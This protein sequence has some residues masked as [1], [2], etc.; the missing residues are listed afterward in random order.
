MILWEMLKKK[1]WNIKSITK[2]NKKKDINQRVINLSNRTQMKESTR[3]ISLSKLKI[4][5]EINHILQKVSRLTLI[6]KWSTFQYI[7]IKKNTLISL[8]F[9]INKIK[10]LILKSLIFVSFNI[11]LFIFLIIVILIYLL[12][13]FAFQIVFMIFNIVDKNYISSTSENSFKNMNS[14]SKK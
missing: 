9:N 1:K 11:Y 4:W 10:S 2:M 12:I 3:K 14:F 6:Y 7:I 5:E 13:K 8:T